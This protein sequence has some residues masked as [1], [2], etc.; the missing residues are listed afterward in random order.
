MTNSE[1]RRH[2]FRLAWPIVISMVLIRGVGIA[3]VI[4]IGQTGK[5]PL[6]AIGLGQQIT[7]LGMALA[8]ALSVG[9]NVLVSYY[10]GANKPK[11][12]TRVIN[13]SVWLAVAVG[14]VMLVLGNLLS[15]PVARFMGAE[16]EVLE[17][18]WDYLKLIWTFYTF[19][20]FVYTLTM[21]F[22]GTGD[23]RTPMYVVTV[24]NIVHIVLAYVL[25]YGKLGLPEMS[26][27]GAGYATVVSDL[28]GC[29]MLFFI[30]MRRG[31]IRF[32]AGW[33]RKKDLL[34]LFK[35]GLPVAGERALVSS[36]IALYQ[37]IV[38]HY[39]VA[40]YAATQIVINIEA[41]S[42]LP[43]IAF[44][45]TAQIMVGQNLGARKM[46]Q[47]V[48]SGYQALWIPG[49]FM[50]LLGVSF[51]LIPSIW[52]HMFT[53]DPEVVP[54]GII[55]C[56]MAAFMQTPLALT[57]V[58]GGGLRGAGETRWV[59]YIT[60]IGAWGVRLSVA[61][62]AAYVFKTGIFWVWFAMFADWA[63][64]AVLMFWRYRKGGWKLVEEDDDD[65]D[66]TEIKPVSGGYNVKK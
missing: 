32:S 56:Q 47:A 55:V 22:Q 36:G 40:A 2:I 10:T 8:Y 3:D 42:F 30:A 59:M 17:L 6:A 53:S 57:M 19:R 15:R 23:S 12:R 20:V 14:V 45:Q 31:L 51:L 35:L 24:T 11:R 66:E 1:L 65:D 49:I 27:E 5:N 9:V 46:D 64:R 50:T 37:A 54:L 62:L 4:I 7:F 63:A 38:L 16:A 34:R 26:T 48:R 13:T 60:F 52:V 21:I 61:L 25:V 33:M 58:F 28:M 18:A 43:G 44:M 29:L 41:F 39:S